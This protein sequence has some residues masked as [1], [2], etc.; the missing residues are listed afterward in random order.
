MELKI[1]IPGQIVY[2]KSGRDKNR[3]YII[4]EVLDSNYVMIVDGMYRKVEKPK[5][6]KI[7]HLVILK[8]IASDIKEKIESGIKL[9]NNDI[10]NCLKDM[11]YINQS[12]NR[13]D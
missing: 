7:M 1:V 4:T 6:K 11:G 10:K 2:S 5:K 8:N 12:A 13:E 9:T 3:Y